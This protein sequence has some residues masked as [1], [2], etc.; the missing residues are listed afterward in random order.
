MRGNLG[1][2]FNFQMSTTA[3]ASIVVT[4]KSSQALRAAKPNRAHLDSFVESTKPGS[5]FRLTKAMFNMIVMAHHTMPA[6]LELL[7]PFRRSQAFSTDYR[8]CTIKLEAH[9][10]LVSLAKSQSMPTRIGFELCYSLKGVERASEDK[11][12]AVHQM[13]VFCEFDCKAQRTAWIFVKEN[14]T[15]RE[16]LRARTKSGHS[17][18][19]AQNQTLRRAFD[20]YLSTHILCCE[21]ACHN[22]GQLISSLEVK[23]RTK[24]DHLTSI[25]LENNVI[26]LPAMQRFE[27]KPTAPMPLLRQT[28]KFSMGGLSRTT[29]KGIAS[30]WR[31]KAALHS[32]I[33]HDV[34]EPI[35]K[36]SDEELRGQS[37]PDLLELHTF[38]EEINDILAMI[39]SD[40]SVMKEMVGHF[41]TLTQDP[42]FPREI[43]AEHCYLGLRFEMQL[44][45]LLSDLRLHES[46]LQHVLQLLTNRKVMV[47]LTG[48]FGNMLENELMR[49]RYSVLWTT[50]IA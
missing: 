15:I 42:D 37:V 19:S 46:R 21:W 4:C 14:D 38:E 33:L 43:S 34:A 29:R 24:T 8:F 17:L 11:P 48:T 3:L 16:K 45:S 2:N 47:S 23:L 25:H 22:W 39:R 31:S 18:N 20:T 28:H 41:K 9:L 5:R 35:Q 40:Q 12:W 27:R 49:C 1:S 36:S 10:E 30:L 44:R 50:K 32:S 13:A 26:D 7:L 6:F